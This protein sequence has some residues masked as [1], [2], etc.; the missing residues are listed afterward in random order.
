MKASELLRA[1]DD[2]LEANGADLPTSLQPASADEVELLELALI[3]YRRDKLEALRLAL[4]A[5]EGIGHGGS[6]AGVP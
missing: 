1:I 3:L 5:A 6:I 4:M 2:E